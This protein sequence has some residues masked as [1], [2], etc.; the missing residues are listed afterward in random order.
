MN[1]CEDKVSSRDHRYQW[2]TLVEANLSSLFELALLLTASPRSAEAGL[3][4]SI[5]KIDMSLPPDLEGLRA[6]VA[7]HSI[8]SEIVDSPAERVNACSMISGRLLPIIHLERLPRICLVLRLLL[9]CTT[10]RCVAML[11]IDD[12]DV[13]MLVAAAIM[14]IQSVTARTA[15]EAG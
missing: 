5:G 6:S 12:A 7:L 1:I 4:S 14:Q 15:K 8:R 10:S 2:K 11:G 13:K 3:L 9:G